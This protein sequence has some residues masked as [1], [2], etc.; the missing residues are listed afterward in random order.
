MGVPGPEERTQ[1]HLSSAFLF[2]LTLP[3][4]TEPAMG[5]GRS[6]LLSSLM[7]CQPPLE[8]TSQTHPEIWISINPVKL[9]SKINHRGIQGHIKNF[10]F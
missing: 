1:V 5:E 6:S 7:K 8:T 4:S 3:D 10:Y 2:H 9:T